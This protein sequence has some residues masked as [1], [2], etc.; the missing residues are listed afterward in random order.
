MKTLDSFSLATDKGMNINSRMSQ[1]R[2]CCT[3]ATIQLVC[4]YRAFLVRTQARYKV[5]DTVTCE[6]EPE[7]GGTSNAD[8]KSPVVGD[9]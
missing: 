6:G 2:P 4:R 8:V 3:R 7:S 5:T 9:R 1:V